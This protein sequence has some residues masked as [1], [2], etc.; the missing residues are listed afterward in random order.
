[1]GRGWPQKMQGSTRVRKQIKTYFLDLGIG[2]DAK[3]PLWLYI[4]YQNS[5]YFIFVI[6]TYHQIWRY[7]GTGLDSSKKKHF[8]ILF[9]PGNQI[10]NLICFLF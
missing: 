8:K 3:K 9:T 7:F 4:N 2:Q 6:K 5:N 10:S 1:M